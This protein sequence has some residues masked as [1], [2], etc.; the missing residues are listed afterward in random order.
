MQAYM[1]EYPVIL[2]SELVHMNYFNHSFF[3]QA[4]GLVLCD[5][6][7]TTA[8]GLILFVC[9]ITKN[10]PDSLFLLETFQPLSYTPLGPTV[11]SPSP[12]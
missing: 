8:P 10:Q 11:F 5:L 4:F 7:T 3:E 6:A 2:L 12:N 1:S 9:K